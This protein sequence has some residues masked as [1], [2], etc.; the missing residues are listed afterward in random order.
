[1]LTEQI[2]PGTYLKVYK[3][4]IVMVTEVKGLYSRKS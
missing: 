2:S 3:V 1:M 4:S